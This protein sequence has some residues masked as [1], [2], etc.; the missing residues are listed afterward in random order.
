MGTE[1]GGTSSG[2]RPPAS[3]L[4]FAGLGFQ[5][6]AAIL[7]FLYLGKW[8]DAKFGTA[9]YLLILGTFVGAAGGFYSM[10]RKLTRPPGR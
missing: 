8:L 1:K 7:L 4:E 9:P 10:Y 6:V 2:D 3:G 5:F